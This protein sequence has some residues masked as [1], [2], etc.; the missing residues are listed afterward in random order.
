VLQINSFEL[1]M[2]FGPVIVLQINS[3]ELKMDFG[4]TE[5][6]KVIYKLKIIGTFIQFS[7]IHFKTPGN[8]EQM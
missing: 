5:T 6:L 4:R 1:K 3:F 2:D 8:C 7:N